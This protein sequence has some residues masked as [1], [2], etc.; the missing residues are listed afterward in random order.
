MLIM[1]MS[2]MKLRKR[3]LVLKE[4][5]VGEGEVVHGIVLIVCGPLE[6]PTIHF[7]LYLALYS[8][9]VLDRR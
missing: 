2:R 5:P 4:L 3:V 8:A 6:F 9:W 1:Y 7:L